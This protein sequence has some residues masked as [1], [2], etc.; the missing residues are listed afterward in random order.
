MMELTPGLELGARFVLVRRIGRGGSAEVWLAVDRPRGER[1]ALK[2]FPESFAADAPRIARLESEVA[3]AQALPGEHVVRVHGI[4]RHEGRVFLVMEYLEGGDLGQLRGRSFA[5]WARAADGIA[6][7]LEAVHAAGLVH[8][9]L[10]CANVF[11]DGAGRAKLGDF[12]L[13]ALAGAARDG[14][15]P[16]NASPQQLRGEPA[17]PADDLYAL[18]ALLYEL[19]A[20]HPPYYP[21]ITRDRVLH[22]PV[23]PLLPRGEVPVAVR[24]LTLRLLA[25][26]AE[27][28]PASAREVRRVLAGLQGD[29]ETVEPLAVALPA[30]GRPAPRRGYALPLAFAAAVLVA[31]A[32]FAWLQPRFA[33]EE[34]AIVAGARREAEEA[35]ASRRSQ[36][37]RLASEISVREAA[38]AA[39]ARFE[40][41]FKALEGRS[42]ARWAT[43]MFAEARDAGADAAQRYAVGDHA[44]AAA[45]W[46]AAAAQLAALEKSVPAALEAAMK[47]GQAALSAGKTDVARESFRFALA[48]QANHPPAVAGLARADRLEAALALVDGAQRDEQA[49]RADAAEAAYRKALATDAAVPGAQAGLDRLTARRNADAFSVAMSRGFADAAAGRSESARTAF[50]QALA[51]RPGSKEAADALAAIERGERTSA[52][53]LLES[54]ARTAEADERWDEALAAWREAAGLEPT[55]ESARDGLARATPRAE[56]QRAIDALNAKP[57][58][59]WEPAARAEARNLLAAAATTGNPRARLAAAARELERLA[60]A[61]ESPVRLRLESDGQ[62][63]VVIYRVGQYG[64]FSTRDVELLPGRYTVVGTR[65]GYRD[66]RREVVLPPGAAPAALTVRCEEPI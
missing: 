27:Q 64:T 45:G 55:L 24:E 16:Y 6:A 26:S 23:P 3:R 35:S 59:L 62:T 61:A 10:K 32:A 8:R 65:N 21:E 15:S 49:G 14:G 5:S 47:R 51:L 28:R 38:D 34:S 41:A 37:E 40:A 29:N 63:Q 43:A 53:Q 22:E 19:I 50:G 66:V 33:G 17:T 2:F 36:A 44:A 54:R 11:L 7:A 9:D 30:G 18:G 4:E 52:L 39:R 20:G 56:L 31:V 42:A 12:G 48:I 13:A 25:K 58:R 1:V 60:K 57:E 46:D